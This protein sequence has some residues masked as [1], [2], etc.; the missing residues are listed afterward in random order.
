MKKKA[1]HMGRVQINAFYVVDMDNPEMI[2][3]AKTA[4]LED[5]MNAAKYNELYGWIEPIEDDTMDEKDICVFLL[6]EEDE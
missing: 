4:L 1:K 2:E 3:H 5:L 6:D